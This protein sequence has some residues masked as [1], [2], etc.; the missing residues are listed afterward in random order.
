MKRILI[1]GANS[2]IGTSFENFMAQFGEDYQI[3]T[4]DM[5]G[6]SWREKDF[7]GYDSLIHVAGIV[8]VKEKNDQLYYQVNRDLAVETAKKAKKDGVKQF[9]F[10]SSMSIYGMD[11]GVIT[12]ETKPNPKNAYGKSKL[13]AEEL[14]RELQADDFQICVLRPPM[15]YGPN[16]VGNYPRL[17]KLAKKT[18][19]FPKVNNQRSMLYIGNLSA[20]LKLM[21]DT[22]LS[23]TF[24]PQNKEYVNTSEMV[25]LIAKT[26][27]KK[28]Y[29]V[30]GFSGIITIFSSQVSTLRKVFG[31]LVYDEKTQGF[32]GSICNNK[33]MTYQNKNFDDSILETEL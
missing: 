6:N 12:K 2:Y 20:F 9:I 11:T 1:T 24:H 4:I 23:G 5:R 25:K 21:I 26:N 18:P 13:A 8:H 30:P 33:L 10:F 3:D 31:T 22:T 7:S 27:R 16:S 32:P 19:I 14:L 17:A 15:I 29:L 28:L